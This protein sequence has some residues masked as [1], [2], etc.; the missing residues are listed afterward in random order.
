MWGGKTV[1]WGERMRE[2]KT[3]EYVEATLDDIALAN[4]I[5]AEVLGRSLDEL[6]PQTRRLLLVL[7]DFVRTTCE[8]NGVDRSDMHFT[9]RDVRAFS[10]LSHDQLW[11]H[12]QRLVMLEYLLVHRGGR[13]Q[14]FVYELLYDGQGKDGTPFLVGLADVEA[15]AKAHGL[16]VPKEILPPLPRHEPVGE[17]SGKEE[18]D[19]RT[20]PTSAGVSRVRLGA[21]WVGPAGH[22]KGL[23]PAPGAGLGGLGSKTAENAHQGLAPET[24][25]DGGRTDGT[26][27]VAHRKLVLRR[28]SRAL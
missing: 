28:V 23:A 8:E 2:Q 24:H 13:G 26:G 20:T 18:G 17:T 7:D 21:F 19:E 4:R 15:L 9:L 22:R 14:T 16:P 3:K 1:G 6:P 10:G 27:D 12:M 5:A 25:D 11:R